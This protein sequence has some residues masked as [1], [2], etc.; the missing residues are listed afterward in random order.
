LP[1][2]TEEW[3]QYGNTVTYGSLNLLVKGATPLEK[4]SETAWQIQERTKGRLSPV[5]GLQIMSDFISYMRQDYNYT[6]PGYGQ[7]PAPLMVRD[8]GSNLTAAKMVKFF[9]S[10]GIPYKTEDFYKVRSWLES[11]QIPLEPDVFAEAWTDETVVMRKGDP[12]NAN[13]FTPSF[14]IGNLDPKAVEKFPL[15]YIASVILSF[16]D[17]IS[18]EISEAPQP[19]Y[20][21]ILEWMNVARKE[22]KLAPVTK[23]DLAAVLEVFPISVIAGN[24]EMAEQMR[25]IRGKETVAPG[26]GLLLSSDHNSLRAQIMVKE[27]LIFDFR[28]KEIVE[29]QNAFP[30]LAT[31]AMKR[32]DQVKTPFD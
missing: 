16:A 30:G 17:L 15:S 19:M 9:E 32:L 14:E 13:N 12:R 23:V 7:S 31:N 29:L 2:T 4:F 25:I 22:Y 27:S 26:A 21:S 3:A 18:H 11:V 1:Q 20:S 6:Y 10:Y 5:Q 8:R 28:M 24:K